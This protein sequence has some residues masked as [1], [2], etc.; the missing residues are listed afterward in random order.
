MDLEACNYDASAPYEDGSC[1]YLSCAG[2]TLDGACNYDAEATIED[3]TCEF[4]MRGLHVSRGRQ[5]DPNATIDDGSCI[6]TGQLQAVADTGP[7]VMMPVWNN[8][9]GM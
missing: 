7:V 8:G 2:C 5:R 1:E 9:V 4:D 3:G 6:T